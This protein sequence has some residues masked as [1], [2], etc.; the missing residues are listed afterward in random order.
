MIP[1][2]PKRGPVLFGERGMRLPL[3]AMSFADLVAGTGHATLTAGPLARFD[4]PGLMRQLDRYPY[5]C[6]EQLTSAALP[7][8]AAG[9]LAGPLTRTDVQERVDSA[10]ARILTRQASNG[11]FGLWRAQSGE[12]WLDAYVTDFLSR[13]K[14]A[15]YAVP[16]LAFDLALDNLRNRVNYASDFEEGGEE[17]AYALFVLARE[18]AASMGDLRYYADA[19]AKAFWHTFGAGPVGG[20]FGPIRRSVAQR[21]DC[22][23]RLRS[24]WPMRAPPSRR[25]G[26]I[27]ALTC[28]TVPVFYALPLSLAAQRSTKTNWRKG[29]GV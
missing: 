26:M 1:K 22:L 4:V 29:W 18:G 5:G 25:G 9:D 24:S 21:C 7:L 15:G 17:I 10:I 12:F 6:T 14:S 28:V 20:S 13:A 16:D 27:S 8:L 3:T 19:K 11:A 23:P 2:F